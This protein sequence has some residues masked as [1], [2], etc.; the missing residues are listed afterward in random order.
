MRYMAYLLA[1]LAVV[2]SA[3]VAVAADS[4]TTTRTNG[5]VTTT[6]QGRDGGISKNVT[7]TQDEEIFE[8]QTDVVDQWRTSI[9][10]CQPSIQ[11][12]PHP[13]IPGFTIEL[14]V[15]GV[16]DGK[17]KATQTMPNN[18]LMSCHFTDEQRQQIQKGTQEDF[19]KLMMDQ[20]T[21]QIT[22][23]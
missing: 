8:K 20:A 17:C 2:M 18:G 14:Q 4:V 23:Y 7:I 12:L 10:S 22:G 15:H 13:M 21:C 5:Q 6:I 1:S 16:Q 3:S 11:K 19:E 9:V